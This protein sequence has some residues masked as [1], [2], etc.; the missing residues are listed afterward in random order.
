MAYGKEVKNTNA[1]KKHSGGGT[2]SLNQ[3]SKGTSS[4]DGS[5][6]K[7]SCQRM[8]HPSPKNGPFPK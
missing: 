3:A 4:S 7:A 8:T 1:H 6:S 5:Q 2:A